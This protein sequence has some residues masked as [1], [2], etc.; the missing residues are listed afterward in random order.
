M[1][2]P[3]DKTKDIGAS[4]GNIDLNL[5]YNLLQQNMLACNQVKISKKQKRAR[6][7][8]CT[9][10]HL[11]RPPYARNG[12]LVENSATE[13]VCDLFNPPLVIKDLLPI[14]V[15][16][17]SNMF[18]VPNAQDAFILSHHGSFGKYTKLRTIEKLTHSTVTDSEPLADPTT[19][20]LAHEEVLYLMERLNAIRIRRETSFEDLFCASD[21][22]TSLSLHELKCILASFDERFNVKYQSYVAFRTMGYIP[23][24]GLRYGC[25]MLV[26]DGAPM[27]TH[28]KYCVYVQKECQDMT[29][30]ATSTAIPHTTI[31]S[32]PS[33]PISDHIILPALT[34]VTPTISLLGLNT[35]L[36]T[37]VARFSHKQTL[38]VSVAD[39]VTESSDGSVTWTTGGGECSKPSH[40]G[41]NQ[42]VSPDPSSNTTDLSQKSH[43][44]PILMSS[45]HVTDAYD[46]AA[47]PLWW[48]VGVADEGE[49]Q[50][51]EQDQRRTTTTQATLRKGV[52]PAVREHECTC[53]AHHARDEADADVQLDWSGP[54]TCTGMS[55]ADQVREEEHASDCVENSECGEDVSECREGVSG[56]GEDV[57]GCGESARGGLCVCEGE[58]GVECGCE[59]EC[60]G[61]RRKIAKRDAHSSGYVLYV[62]AVT[63]WKK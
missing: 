63:S 8:T 52:V 18:L 11:Q 22:A 38:Y 33:A 5:R 12:G 45:P 19:Y 62:Q 51:W 26:Y 16:Y 46:P 47:D 50:R 44:S 7:A 31:A 57:S 20:A 53:V 1:S 40:A 21:T 6:S 35:C 17:F 13:H 10:Q 25:D 14:T 23:K 58:S 54:C 41:A 48:A 28:S 3:D 49:M 27:Q 36:R 55:A 59:D 32:S 29:T 61:G 43:F 4:R 2:V 56:F 30:S 42:H 39:S 60:M 37:R 24:S 15:V 9:A 34:P